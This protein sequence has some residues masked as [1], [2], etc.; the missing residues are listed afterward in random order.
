MQALFDFFKSDLGVAIAWVCTVVST[1]ACF[2][3]SGEA[4]RLK[5]KVKELS[6]VSNAL[7][8]DSVKISGNGNIYTKQN[9]GGMNIKM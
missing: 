4:R 2:V 5:V 8:D 7:G 1:I 9:S 3:K 6:L